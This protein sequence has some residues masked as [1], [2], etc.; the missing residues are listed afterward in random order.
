M[1]PGGP[2]GGGGCCSGDPGS[3]AP[4]PPGAAALAAPAAGACAGLPLLKKVCSRSATLMAV[5]SRNTSTCSREDTGVRGVHGQCQCCCQ[6]KTHLSKMTQLPV[7]DTQS[8]DMCI[9]VIKQVAAIP[10]Q[11]Q[12]THACQWQGALQRPGPRRLLRGRCWRPAGNPGRQGQQQGQGRVRRR[13][14]AAGTGAAGG[15]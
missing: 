15:W 12:H 5:S 14:G 4:A 2:T 1:P 7:H 6:R 11:H 13:Q 8:L 9:H 3:P 10:I